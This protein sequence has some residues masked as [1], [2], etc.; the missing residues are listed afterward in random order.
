MRFIRALYCVDGNF[1]PLTG[2][3][4][5]ERDC[6][7]TAAGSRRFAQQHPALFEA[8]GFADHP[9]PQGAVP[10]NV[11]TPDEPDYADLASLP[12]L[13][14]TLD[15]ALAVYRSN[16]RLPIYNTEFG[17]QTNP[18][19]TIARAISPSLASLYINQAEY[20]G[21]RDPRLSSWDQYLLTDSPSG[22]FATGLEFANGKPKA[23]YYAFRMPLYLP[24]ASASRNHPL[25]VWGCV[26]PAHYFMHAK[27][28]Q[29]VSIQFVPATGGSFRTIK[30]VPLTDPY[31]YFDVPVT[32]PSTGS[33]RTAWSYPSGEEI[34][35][36]IAQVTIR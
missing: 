32:F 27:K 9:Y 30:K 23:I 16:R 12:R 35:S 33:V 20:L 13:E 36:R 11:V 25:D 22:N 34:H 3:A 21:W 24:L 8:T 10:P 31:G 1:Q 7:T 14:H 15:R 4:A 17:Y 19:E 28:Q 18:P 2:G 5:A 6:P 29:I 26:R